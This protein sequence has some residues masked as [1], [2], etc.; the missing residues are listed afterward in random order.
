MVVLTIE[1][2][3]YLTLEDHD[4]SLKADDQKEIKTMIKLTEK[5]HG[6]S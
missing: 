6:S 2:L 5:N 1:Q 4:D 3:L